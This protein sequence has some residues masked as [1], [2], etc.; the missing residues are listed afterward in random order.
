MSQ[1]AEPQAADLII[2]NAYVVTVNPRRQIYADDAVAIKGQRH[3]RGRTRSGRD[4]GV[5]RATG[6]RRQRQTRIAR[7]DRWPQPRVPV[8]AP[9]ASGDDVDIMTCL[10]QNGSIPA[11]AH[12]T[13]T[14]AYVGAVA[15][16]NQ[17][18]K[19]GTTCFND[20]GGYHHDDS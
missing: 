17:M 15:N 5:S 7:A 1:T 19:S 16:Y 6:H 12:V 13:E 2:A 4:G 14:E 11:R 9:K 3:C 20:P 18:I 8:I 10:S